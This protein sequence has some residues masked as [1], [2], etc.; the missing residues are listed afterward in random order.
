MIRPPR[1]T[2]DYRRSENCI[3]NYYMYLKTIRNT[4]IQLC[5]L[6][7]I[8]SQPTS[9]LLWCV[10]TEL[11]PDGGTG[12]VSGWVRR[13]GEMPVCIAF[14]GHVLSDWLA[15]KATDYSERK[16]AHHRNVEYD[17]K[18]KKSAREGGRSQKKKEMM[19]MTGKGKKRWN[20]GTSTTW[21]IRPGHF[22]D[23][24]LFFPPS[25]TT[26]PILSAT[27]LRLLT[28]CWNRFRWTFSSSRQKDV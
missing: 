25:L 26:L 11:P 7:C 21:C 8:I 16:K 23:F 3:W 12:F 9:C 10:W 6:V 18:K 5:V 22:Q 1:K 17:H 28:F 13:G 24:L 2:N 27:P 4:I 14:Y 19:M 20:K 15:G